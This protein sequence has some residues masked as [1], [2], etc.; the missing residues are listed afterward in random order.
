MKIW[1]SALG[2]LLFWLA[3]LGSM[4]TQGVSSRNLGLD[5]DSAV[6]LVGP[7]DSRA[8]SNRLALRDALRRHFER[9]P[10]STMPFGL[11]HVARI[12]GRILSDRVDRSRANLTVRF[13]DASVV[14]VLVMESPTSRAGRMNP[15]FEVRADTVVAPGLPFV[16][17]SRGQFGRFSYS[18]NSRTLAELEELARRYGIHAAT[19]LSEGRASAAPSMAC[20]DSGGELRCTVRLKIEQGDSL[21]NS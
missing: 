13:S 3:A 10:A 19:V 7:E 18:G 12:A 11:E 17:Q 4:Q 5:L 1:R 2:S 15:E 20:D 9:R 21:E 14:Q 6:A 8:G 16:P